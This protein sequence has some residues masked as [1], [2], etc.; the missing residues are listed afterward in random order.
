M[1]DTINKY[2]IKENVNLREFSK[3]LKNIILKGVSG[4]YDVGG[5]SVK[6]I[7]AGGV[8]IFNYPNTMTELT[9]KLIDVSDSLGYKF[10]QIGLRGKG[11][12]KFII[13]VK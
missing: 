10:Q 13:D 11:D 9:L 4:S 7:K 12:M 2:M 5:Y 3:K 6:V 1:I 8:L